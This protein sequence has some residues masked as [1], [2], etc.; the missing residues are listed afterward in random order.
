MKVAYIFSRRGSGSSHR[1][2]LMRSPELHL[3]FPVISTLDERGRAVMRHCYCVQRV[4]TVIV[5]LSLVFWIVGCGTSKEEKRVEADQLFQQAVHL[6]DQG[7]YRMSEE[8]F[9]SALRIDEDLERKGKVGEEYYYLGLLQISR[10]RYDDGLRFYAKALER[11]RTGADRRNEVLML[12]HIARVR[13]D[14]GDEKAALAYLQEALTIGALFD[15]PSGRALT[16]FNLARVFREHGNFDLSLQSI[17]QSS[18]LYATLGDSL[19][20]RKTIEELGRTYLELGRYA[21]AATSFTKALDFV[22]GEK[23]ERI[24]FLTRVGIAQR[25]ADDA[26]R[27]LRSLDEAYR[28]A[29]SDGA[30]LDEQIL[31]MANVGH[32]YFDIQAYE[33]AR[34]FYQSALTAA[35]K[36]GKKSEQGY[37]LLLL[38]D[39][40][41][42]M[43]RRRRFVG[44]LE[45]AVAYATEASQLFSSMY[46]RRGEAA[47]K[48]RLGLL[49]SGQR[50]RASAVQY[51]KEAIELEEDNFIRRWD[52]PQDLLSDLALF[53]EYSMWYDSAVE[54]LLKL[55]RPEEALWYLERKLQHRFQLLWNEIGPRLREVQAN[56]DFD[57]LRTLRRH[58]G[59]VEKALVAERAKPDREQNA[60]RLEGLQTL[61]TA[62]KGSF[63]KRTDEISARSPNL[64]WLVKTTAASL[65]DIQSALSD[66]AA[67][68]EYVL[69]EDDVSII[70]VTKNHIVV[71]R[72]PARKQEI[73][74]SVA[75][76]GELIGKEEKDGI[77]E[78]L[79]R[80]CYRTLLQPL[81]RS[82]SGLRR[83]II[84]LP[85][86]FDGFP[87]HA[88]AQPGGKGDRPFIVA[89]MGIHYVP[90]AAALMYERSVSSS[91]TRVFAVGNASGTEWD[92]EYEF[93]D[94]RSF[95]PGISLIMGER[96]TLKALMELQ[97][98]MLYLS[99]EFSYD[100]RNPENS[101]FNLAN[102]QSQGTLSQASLAWLSSLRPFTLAVL[103]N[104]EKQQYGVNLAHAQ[105]MLLG[106]SR[107][108]VANLWHHD[109]RAS[110]RFTELLYSAML[111]G[112]SIPDAFHQ[113]QVLLSRN[114]EFSTPRLWALF[115]LF[116]V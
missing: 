75:R 24:L 73:M 70:L 65:P 21:E 97:G 9:L 32:V 104:Q 96:A 92:V 110:K 47:A 43:L 115:F 109:R 81:E 77:V 48:Y 62:Q 60:E 16:Q 64:E 106:G 72:S 52:L 27:A 98:D 78:S 71:R 46:F 40:E 14:L 7:A 89:R 91:L 26:K 17:G 90:L 113:A 87:L 56:A 49:R 42:E 111:E 68:I 53:N 80:D 3:S 84:V 33:N 20:L 67:L 102:E 28:L 116:G 19:G 83:L 10:G 66:S 103:S 99:S 85:P 41:R 59:V 36:A 101:S 38:S 63:Y 86:E 18:S 11:Y 29:L 76:V 94:M 108:V 95:F 45:K 31:V 39:V 44:S 4:F 15:D 82:I 37:L 79:M 88:C 22:G 74:R 13:A 51:F 35:R 69:G 57:S 105:L 107:Y 93:K 58:I 12:N 112:D 114:P 54:T 25:R 30:I 6:Y 23:G 34:E 2:R 55:Q 1:V 61:W 5:G 8:L 50:E 100:A